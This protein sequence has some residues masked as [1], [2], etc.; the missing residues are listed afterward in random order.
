MS[1]N[2]SSQHLSREPITLS[3]DIFD[4]LVKLHII[5]ESD[6]QGMPE[7]TLSPKQTN[8][9]YNAEIFM[10]YLLTLRRLLVSI[11]CP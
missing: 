6:R 1:K 2:E 8:M 11:I 3:K 4:K 10:L 5:S 9:F 7:L